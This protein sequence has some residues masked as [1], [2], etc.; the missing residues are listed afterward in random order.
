[1]KPGTALVCAEARMGHSA[2]RA[3]HKV[4]RWRSFI[5]VLRRVRSEL[6]GSGFGE[7]IRD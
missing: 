4:G 2:S 1:M 7:K 5:R 3:A 6:D